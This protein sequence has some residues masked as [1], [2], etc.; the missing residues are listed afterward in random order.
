MATGGENRVLVSE[1]GVARF[2]YVVY[3][4]ELDLVEVDGG[5]Y[6]R[7]QNFYDRNMAQVKAM[8]AIIIAMIL[9]CLLTIL[10]ISAIIYMVARKVKYVTIRRKKKVEQA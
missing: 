5:T 9:A 8:P 1:N 7:L 4:D 3:P 10:L 6:D 2:K